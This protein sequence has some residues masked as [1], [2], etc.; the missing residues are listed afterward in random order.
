MSHDSPPQI[1]TG[2]AESSDVHVE[3]RAGL[4][5]FNTPE[6][7][8]IRSSDMKDDRTVRSKCSN[9]NISSIESPQPQ[10]FPN[11]P[12]YDESYPHNQTSSKTSIKLNSGESSR[13]VRSNRGVLDTT[14]GGDSASVPS[15]RPNISSHAKFKHSITL[16]ES[17]CD[18]YS[19]DYRENENSDLEH[20]E[21]DETSACLPDNYDHGDRSQTGDHDQENESNNH[22]SEFGD[23]SGRR[24]PSNR[25]FLKVVLSPLNKIS[26]LRSKSSPQPYSRYENE[27]LSERINK[28]NQTYRAR[29][30]RLARTFRSSYQ[31]S[32]A[33]V[34]MAISK[35]LVNS[36]LHRST[37]ALLGAFLIHIT[38]GTIYTLSNVNSYMISYIRK[39]VDP[40]ATYGGAMWISAAYAIGQGFSMVLG[41][42]LEKRFSARL[43]CSLGCAIHSL[44]IIST[45]WSIQHGPG[46]VLVTYG[47]LPGF[48]C[49]LAYMTPMSNGFGWFPNRKGLVAGVILAGFGIGTFVFNMAQTAFVNPRNLSPEIKDDGYF[50][51]DEILN[52]VPHLFSFM[53]SIYAL[54]QFIGCLLLF[55]PPINASDERPIFGESE[56]DIKQ[57]IRTR[58][59]MVLFIVYGVTTPGVLFINSTLKKY[60][61]YYIHNDIYL[62]WTGSMA[63]IANALGRLVWGLAVDKYSFTACFSCITILFTL[64]LFMTPFEFVLSSKVLFLVCTLVIFG[65]FSGWM[66]TYPVHLSRIFGRTNSGVIYGLIFISQAVGGVFAA[67]GTHYL[68]DHYNRFVPFHAVVLLEIVGLLVYHMFYPRQQTLNR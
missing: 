39:N 61:Q 45:S 46:A 66:S 10:D 20:I 15:H 37:L 59:F 18:K 49:G 29:K 36:L 48:G 47:L 55:K 57:A 68:I 1:I 21:L 32:R 44:S 6:N 52:R 43:A 33:E 9:D 22:T 53:G 24:T 28:Y 26:I 30:S 25:G 17:N 5:R 12:I 56:L 7:R 62:A 64:G 8:E 41:G 11:S 35:Q 67:F 4:D 63:S 38:L 50:T 51:Q 2:A 40:S 65:S 14:F 19:T 58:E 3:F 16:N 54:M 31:F 23:S 34:S 13:R 27:D 60:G 42:Y